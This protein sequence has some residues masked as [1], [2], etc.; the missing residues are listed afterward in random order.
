MGFPWRIFFSGGV[1]EREGGTQETRSLVFRMGGNSR[2]RAKLSLSRAPGG[3]SKRNVPAAADFR[4]ECI[5]GTQAHQVRVKTLSESSPA[6]R[7]S[8]CLQ[9][10]LI[11]ALKPKGKK[12]ILGERNQE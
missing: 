1:L 2:K 6:K 8:L 9:A 7:C 12:S 4:A 5:G 11:I 3:G 10:Q